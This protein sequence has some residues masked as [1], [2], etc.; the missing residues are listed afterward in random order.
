MKLLELLCRI[1]G[2]EIVHICMGD[3]SVWIGAVR[4]MYDMDERVL[5]NAT[6]IYISSGF[7]GMRIEVII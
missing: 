5:S 2:D 7:G 3:E 6:V 1:D 4:N